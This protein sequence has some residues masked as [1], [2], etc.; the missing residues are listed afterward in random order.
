MLAGFNPLSETMAGRQRS[1]NDFGMLDQPPA[2]FGL[3][4]VGCTST[5]GC[6]SFTP[7][8]MSLKIIAADPSRANRSLDI[9]APFLS[10]SGRRCVFHDAEVYPRLLGKLQANS[11]VN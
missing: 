1:K 3:C 6:S 7:K 9:V 2:C 10:L 8:T 11:E 4:L 5:T